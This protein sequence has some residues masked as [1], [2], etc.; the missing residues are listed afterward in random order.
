MG[1]E[2]Q[3]GKGRRNIGTINT[4]N[5]KG[6]IKRAQLTNDTQKAIFD[7]VD[8][9]KNGV[10]DATEMQEFTNQL[11]QTAGNDK[12]S[13]R[14]AGKLLKQYKNGDNTQN[15]NLK[16]IDKKEILSFIKQLS[17]NSENIQSTQVFENNGEKTIVITYKD[18]SVETIN[19]DNTSQ[20]ATTDENNTVTTKFYDENHKFNKESIVQ[21]NGD[22]EVTEY[23]E[24]QPQK[25]TI[26]LADGTK[27]TVINYKDGK[28]AT[29]TVT[30]GATTSSFEY[31]DGQPRLTKKVIKKGSDMTDE[32]QY[33]YNDDGVI[34]TEGT[35][36]FDADG[37]VI[38]TKLV[39][40]KGTENEQ[41]TT[42]ELTNFGL[43]TKTTIENKNGKAVYLYSVPE[44]EGEDPQLQGYDIKR[45]DGSSE[46][47]YEGSNGQ[48]VVVKHDKDGNELYQEANPDG[49]LIRARFTPKKGKFTEIH[50]DGKGN[51][52]LTVQI[53]ET[54][55]TMAKTFGCSVDDIKALNEGRKFQAGAKVLVPG[56]LNPSSEIITQRQSVDEMISQV[57]HQQTE[58]RKNYFRQL[59]VT[60][61]SKYGQKVKLADKVTFIIG[62]YVTETDR[63]GQKTQ[64]FIEANDAEAK[65]GT[66]KINGEVVAVETYQRTNNKG[67]YTIVGQVGDST[68]YYMV[69]DPES[70]NIYYADKDL[71]RLVDANNANAKRFFAEN[72]GKIEKA[73]ERFDDSCN[74]QDIE[75]VRTGQR[76]RYGNEI[77]ALGRGY[78]GI[79]KKIKTS[80]GKTEER[81]YYKHDDM[82]AYAIETEQ[83][84][85]RSLISK[86]TDNNLK[87]TDTSLSSYLESQGWI[88]DF[89]D[90]C[91]NAWGSNNTEEKVRADLKEYDNQIKSLSNCKTKQEFNAKFQQIFGKQPDLQALAD[92]T[93]NP[94]DENFRA[95]FGT[96]NDIA[97]RVE[98]YIHSQQVGVNFFKG[99]VMTLSGIAAAATG[100]G[101]LVVSAV[102]GGT[103]IALDS[104]DK[105]TSKKGISLDDVPTIL[106]DGTIN[107]ATT[108]LGGKM[109]NILDSGLGQVITGSGKIATASK[110]L[111][112]TSVDAGTVAGVTYASAGSEADWSDYASAGALYLVGKGTAMRARGNSTRNP[113]L[114]PT[115][116][117]NPKPTLNPTPN[118][119]PNPN[120]KPTLNPTPNPT[121]NPNPTVIDTATVNGTKMPGGKLGNAKFEHA[122]AQVIEEIPTAT[123]QRAAQIHQEAHHLQGKS[124][125]QGRE[126]KHI[127]EDGVGYLEIGKQRIPLDTAT[128]EQLQAARKAVS[129]WSTATREKQAILNEIDHQLTLRQKTKTPTSTRSS[130]TVDNINQQMNNNA[131][132]ILNGKKGAI[133]SH[134]AATLSDHITNNLNTVE[135]LE[136]FIGS[137]KNRVGVD[138]NGNMHVYQ[139]EGKDHAAALIKQAQTKINN[140]KAHTAELN[141][142]TGELDSAISAQK[143]LSE[144]QLATTRAFMNKSNSIEELEGLIS[145]MNGSKPIRK[146]N[147][148]RKLISDM[149]AKVDMLK[150]KQIAA[151]SAQTNAP[152]EEAYR[153]PTVTPK[154]PYKNTRL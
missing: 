121:P 28:E 66:M 20:I 137:L 30:E 42:N 135:E 112:M 131:T 142:V 106:I 86:A 152:K 51:S 26:T 47:R 79:I 68:G 10:L 138:S 150:A 33:G 123:P 59:G 76:D 3:L 55:E 72:K 88:G 56:E 16:N 113:N 60:N 143:G 114:E 102:V 122:K 15:S 6:G 25:K 89:V 1:N 62:R 104:T 13:K 91:G 18:G 46:K 61:F 145:R 105:A 84:D 17:Q 50:Y 35:K 70:G 37:K 9:D 29:S 83:I 92:Y 87:N 99:G 127:V 132:A 14:E 64:K 12:L 19:P 151:S 103:S 115:P 2:I 77:V 153:A 71:T 31:I 109:F 128:P 78:Y 110:G 133:G 36:T 85:S 139:V 148:A 96:K 120:P 34:V 4:A 146:S 129:K 97:R 94:S 116:N 32:I 65:Q 45:T 119:T 125:Q 49:T 124:R 11:T 95:A 107:G 5:L 144:Q 149:Q 69:K 21:E 8:K 53:G 126:I 74:S 101:S 39:E 44:K 93:H 41:T 154:S 80:D 48:I 117:P 73:T 108:Y 40:N 130:Q 118:P 136:S 111:I 58:A 82:I 24:E 57:Q 98:K 147:A 81:I 52:E 90:F 100:G 7:L 23:S 38:K 140:I 27:T 141:T 22:S 54:P 63:N 75:F 67:N 43:S 134:D